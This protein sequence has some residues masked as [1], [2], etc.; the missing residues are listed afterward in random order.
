MTN[1]FHWLDDIGLVS[2][3]YQLHHP[4]PS[5]T[6][7]HGRRKISD[8]VTVMFHFLWSIS[9]CVLFCFFVGG[10]DFI[11]NIFV[12]GAGGDL[13]SFWMTVNLLVFLAELAG[14]RRGSPV[15]RWAHSAT[16]PGLSLWGP[17]WA[18]S[19]MQQTWCPQPTKPRGNLGGNIQ[20]RHSNKWSGAELFRIVVCVS[21]EMVGGWDGGG[22][23]IGVKSVAWY[24]YPSNWGRVI[25]CTT[26]T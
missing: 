25:S 1:Y 14:N 15:P 12:G 16:L 17:E 19:V 4:P 9:R 26:V 24:L 10:A 5:S 22:G 11:H 7:K 6:I 20:T 3:S 2:A 21:L 13:L 8:V 18:G 23:V